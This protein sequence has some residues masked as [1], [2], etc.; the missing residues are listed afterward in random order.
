MAFILPKL[1]RSGLA[2]AFAMGGELVR[3][4]TFVR[5]VGLNAA[6]GLSE[7]AER[8]ALCHVLCL[9]FAP[10]NMLVRTQPGDE[11]LIVRASELAGIVSP[12]EH[13]R[14]VETYSGL[15]R[16][17]LGCR[18]DAT[19]EFWVF[20]TERTLDEDWGDLGAAALSEDRG[21][22]TALNL[23]EEWGSLF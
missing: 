7:S 10:Q 11:T 6:T 12:G 23:K 1:V 20:Q 13:D 16:K 18:L 22:F 4:A 21:D 15:V 9:G 2:M 5:P 14:I 19:G 17:V 8:T 3:E